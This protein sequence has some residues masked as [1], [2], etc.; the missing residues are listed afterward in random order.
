MSTQTDGDPRKKPPVPRQNQPKK[1][2]QSENIVEYLEESQPAPIKSARMPQPPEL[3]APPL[4]PPPT[5]D[6]SESG[7]VVLNIQDDK[8]NED[9]IIHTDIIPTQKFRH[10]HFKEI[11]NELDRTFDLDHTNDSTIL[12]II[13]VYVK[14]QKI[15]YTEAKTLCEQRLNALMIPAIFNTAICTIL[16]LVL[17]DISFGATIVSILN[18]INALFLSLIT[19]LKLD[20]RA[21]AH[22]TS[23]YK[24]DKLQSFLEFNSGKVL[25]TLPNPENK[26]EYDIYQIMKKRFGKSKRRISLYCQNECVLNFPHFIARMYSPL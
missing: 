13:V 16:S 26:A 2:E 19:Y 6:I 21:E 20:A 17:K 11:E 22:R 14:G 7:N 25:F 24:F 15:L 3:I 23:A 10:Y 8:S 4:F 12:D 18:G 5:S 9:S 1:S